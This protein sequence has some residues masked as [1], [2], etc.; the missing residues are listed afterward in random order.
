MPEEYDGLNGAEELDEPDE[1][2]GKIELK[3]EIKPIE[4]VN[5]NPK[6]VKI[7]A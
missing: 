1:P 5:T 7:T 4:K 3:A 6:I 2:D